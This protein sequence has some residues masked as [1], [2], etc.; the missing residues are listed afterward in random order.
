MESKSW[1]CIR[2]T[3]KYLVINKNIGMEKTGSRC[4]DGLKRIIVLSVGNFSKILKANESPFLVLGVLRKSK[5]VLGH[6][7][8]RE[9]LNKGKR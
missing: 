9:E 2:K 4:E 3:K 6:G 1:C 5:E 8:N 7:S